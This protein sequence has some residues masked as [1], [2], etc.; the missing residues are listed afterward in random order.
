M[1]H[2]GDDDVEILSVREAVVRAGNGSTC[3][4]ERRVHRGEKPV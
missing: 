3:P 2:G 4:K 1:T